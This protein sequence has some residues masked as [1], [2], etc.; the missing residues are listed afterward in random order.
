MAIRRIAFSTG[1]NSAEVAG[2]GWAEPEQHGRW[3]DGITSHVRIGGLFSGVAYAAEMQ[4]GPFLLPPRVTGQLLTITVNGVLC[5]SEQLT[6]PGKIQF[7]IPPDAIAND[8]VA[9]LVLACPDAVSPKTLG[10]SGDARRLGFSVWDLTLMDQM[11]AM[12]RQVADIGPSAA[13]GYDDLSPVS[14]GLAAQP[15]AEPPRPPV[16][17]AAD[18]AGRGPTAAALAPLLERGLTLDVGRHSYGAP[19]IKFVEHDTTAVLEIG[20]FCSIAEKCTIFVGRFGRHPVDFLTTFPLGMVF[21][22]PTT[23]DDSSVLREDMSVRIG[24]DVWI[25]HGVTIMAGVRIGHGA[26]IGAGAVVTADVPPYAIVGGVPAKVIKYRVAPDHIAR[27]LR[28]AWWDL[29]DSL[30]ESCVECFHRTD[31]ERALSDLEQHLL[32]QRGIPATAT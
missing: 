1:G 11:P 17:S 2:E 8:G 27:L 18:L 23:R 10:M 20:A 5:F 31:T 24:S 32:R 30:I 26:V 21:R 13:R 14:L 15:A 12:V 3:T 22:E 19:D 29:P 25:G 28:I 16:V 9:E 6:G 4:L 7:A